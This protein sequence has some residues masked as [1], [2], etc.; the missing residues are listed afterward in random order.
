MAYIEGVTNKKY[1]ETITQR[2]KKIDFDIVFDSSQLHQMISDNSFTSFPLLLSTER[3]DRTVFSLTRGQVAVFSNGSGYAIIGPATLT[4]FFISPED[5]YL[6]WVLGSFLRLIRIFSVLFSIF[7]TSIYIA[8]LTYHYEM[9]PKVL[10][11]PLS[12]SRHTCVI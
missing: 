1:I 8:V 4:D 3:I 5:Y 9:I 11:G 10:L 6:P 7:A 2:L 12:F